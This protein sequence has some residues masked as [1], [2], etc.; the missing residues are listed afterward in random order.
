[1]SIETI[2]AEVG[3]LLAQ[4]RYD[5]K[6][7]EQMLAGGTA[8]ERI[9]AAGRLVGLKGREQ[10]LEDRMRELRQSSG[11]VIPTVIQEFKEDWMLVMQS[12]FPNDG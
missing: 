11:G 8:E 6:C 9:R 5:I 3:G 2:T 1:M 4:T 12:L 10:E 7:A